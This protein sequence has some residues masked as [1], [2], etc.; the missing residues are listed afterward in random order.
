MESG[1]WRYGVGEVE[2]WRGKMALI[3]AVEKLARD[4]SVRECHD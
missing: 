1:R 4:A 3:I 2:V